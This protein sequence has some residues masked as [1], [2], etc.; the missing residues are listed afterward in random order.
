MSDQADVKGFNEY[1]IKID[2]MAIGPIDFAR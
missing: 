1:T 2:G